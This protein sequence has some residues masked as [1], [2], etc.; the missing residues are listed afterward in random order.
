MDTVLPTLVHSMV[1]PQEGTRQEA[2]DRRDSTPKTSAHELLQH[3]RNTG[4]LQN[5]K[6]A[7]ACG[8]ATKSQGETTFSQ[9]LQN[10]SPLRLLATA[11]YRSCCNTDRKA[12]V[13]QKIIFSECEMRVALFE[14]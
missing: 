12:S 5:G 6:I 14:N 10:S 2:G 9:V 11:C 7:G 13:T 1:D 4:T 3:R 8:Q